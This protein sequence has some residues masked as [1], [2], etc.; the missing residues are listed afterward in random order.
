[1]LAVGL[2]AG[3]C[4]LTDGGV[5]RLLLG[6]WGGLRPPLGGRA[7]GHSASSASK[8]TARARPRPPRLVRGAHFRAR[9]TRSALCGPLEASRMGGMR[10]GFARV[11]TGVYGPSHN[12]AVPEVCLG[13]GVHLGHDAAVTEG[14]CTVTKA[15]CP[16]LLVP[17]GAR[18]VPPACARG[19]RRNRRP[20]RRRRRL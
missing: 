16:R 12:G 15:P 6:G 14:T 17:Q 3:E 20:R 2:C 4:E 9:D 7:L 19:G 5:A 18:G 1:M 8:T 10:A 13:H 11:I